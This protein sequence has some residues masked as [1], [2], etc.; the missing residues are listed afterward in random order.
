MLLVDDRSLQPREN[1]LPV[2]R[3]ELVRRYGARLTAALDAVSIG[4][5]TADLVRLNHIAAVNPVEP[6]EAVAAYLRLTGR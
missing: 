3:T 2:V 4:L 6:A 1:L 5:T